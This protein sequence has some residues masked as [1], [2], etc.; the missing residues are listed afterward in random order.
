MLR[1]QHR[2]FRSVL[3]AADTLIISCAAVLAYFVRFEMLASVVPPRSGEV[4][5][6]ATH[7]IP[8]VTAAPLMLVTMMWA[9]LYLPRRDQR[10]YREAADIFKAVAVGVALT[11]ATISFFREP[12]YNGRD[13]SRWQY[14]VYGVLAVTML[15]TWRLGFRVLLRLLRRR[16][17]NLRHVAIIG[18]G[19]LG[20]VVLQTLRR[21]LWTGITPSYFISHHPTTTRETC[22]GLPVVGGLQN[23]EQV[24]DGSPL[25]GVFIALPGRM[26]AELPDLL[27]RLERFPVDVRVVPDMNPKYMPLNMSVNELDGMPI[28]SVRESPLA[29]WGGIMKRTIDVLGGLAA[30]VIF[31]LPMLVIAGFIRLSGPGPIVFRQERMSL[32]G[33]RFKIFKFRTMHHVDAEVQTLRDA[34]RGTAAWTKPGD[35]RV[36]RIGRI[37]RR[38]SLDELPQLFNVLLGEMSLVGPRPERPEL[39][40]DFR[41]DWRGYMLRQ[42]VKAGMTGWAQVNGLR[43]DTS[44]RKRLQYDLF[45]IRNWSIMFDLRILWMTIFRGFAHPNAG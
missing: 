15:T 10:F 20:Q 8:V 38:T 12:L 37:L 17:W 18:N 22:V 29:G 36:T 11:F 45:Y 14:L 21:N 43:G 34:G 24:L 41:E 32:N 13:P 7:A 19:R 2:F 27:A 25:S 39:I 44:L 4:V 6:Y 1:T 28:L 23:L 30:L 42:N 26:A 35:D 9:R 40:Q 16:G 31:G 5:S 33:Q 3:V